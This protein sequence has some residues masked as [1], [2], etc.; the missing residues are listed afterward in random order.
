MTMSQ[1]A[2]ARGTLTFEFWVEGV[3]EHAAFSLKRHADA[4]QLQPLLSAGGEGG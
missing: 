4:A 3:A 2:V 1:F